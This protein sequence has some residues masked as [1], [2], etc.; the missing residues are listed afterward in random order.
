MFFNASECILYSM[1]NK[2]STLNHIEGS[3]FIYIYIYILV[4]ISELIITIPL[5]YFEIGNLGGWKKR[6]KI[7][8][9]WTCFSNHLMQ[10]RLT[11]NYKINTTDLSRQRE[12]ERDRVWSVRKVGQQNIRYK[13][14]KNEEMSSSTKGFGLIK[15]R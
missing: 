2:I 4:L 14:L 15:V 9:T 3:V 1:L 8:V 5:R 6:R 11:G 13:Q 7:P 12:R 10:A